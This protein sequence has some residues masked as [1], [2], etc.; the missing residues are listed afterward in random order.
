[1][2]EQLKRN[3]ILKGVRKFN[4]QSRVEKQYIKA[5]LPEQVQGGWKPYINM[6]DETNSKV[7]LY[8]CMNIVVSILSGLN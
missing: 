8:V 7:S 2:K 1:M 3:Y 4:I 6:A 5:T